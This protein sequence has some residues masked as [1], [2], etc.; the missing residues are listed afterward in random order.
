M[1]LKKS[2]TDFHNFC[3]K[4][5]GIPMRIQKIGDTFFKNIPGKCSENALK[6]VGGCKI[7]SFQCNFLFKD[8]IPCQSARECA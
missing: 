4:L 8:P 2:L 7:F 5:K 6:I 3:V 1:N